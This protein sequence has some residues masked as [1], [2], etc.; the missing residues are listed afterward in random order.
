MLLVVLGLRNFSEHCKVRKESASHF[1]VSA[2]EGDD[3]SLRTDDFFVEELQEVS[4]SSS[5]QVTQCHDL[6]MNVGALFILAVILHVFPDDLV[7]VV[8]L[9][10]K[11]DS[12]FLHDLYHYFGVN[13]LL[14]TR[15][16][17]HYYY[18]EL[19]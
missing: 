16:T 5:E 13:P 3:V 18:N 2:V 12:D 7:Q 9:F 11:L 6:I 14:S 4:W 15:V 19:P 10:L 8:S 1:G 17:F